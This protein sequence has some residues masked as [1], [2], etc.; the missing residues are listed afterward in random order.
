MFSMPPKEGGGRGRGRGRGRPRAEPRNVDVGSQV[1]EDSI[2]S[3]QNPAE[4]PIETAGAGIDPR[5]LTALQQMVTQAVQAAMA[6]VPPVQVVQP[7]QN[8]WPGI[9]QPVVQAGFSRFM[10]AVARLKPPTFDGSGEPSAV[11]F[12]L[13]RFEK[14]LE[15][16]RCPENEKVTIASYYLIDDASDWW[17]VSRP[18]DHGATWKEFRTKLED[19]FFPEALRDAK[20]H[21][22]KYPENEGLKVQ[23]L[24]VKFNKLLKYAT[25]V[26]R[27]E[28]DKIKHFHRWLYPEIRPLMARHNCTTLEQFIDECLTME[29]T[30][31]GSNQMIEA[32][33]GKKQKTQF[34]PGRTGSQGNLG[35]FRKSFFTPKSAPSTGSV[36][37]SQ[38]GSH[39][40]VNNQS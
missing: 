37:T 24:A 6:Q 11:T 23:Q 14:L 35:G 31:D 15:G 9:E 18:T 27:N 34:T 12:W 21:E 32:R 19:R 25:V 17:D 22:F 30:I 36:K 4:I 39:M 28:K 3:Q 13:N 29:A 26:V 1:A 20:L 7:D 38:G 40:S 5:T 33:A 2:G 8:R 16:I 10:E